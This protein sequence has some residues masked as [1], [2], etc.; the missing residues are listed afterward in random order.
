[1]RDLLQHRCGFPCRV[2]SVVAHLLLEDEFN[3]AL[4]LLLVFAGLQVSYS[5]GDPFLEEAL[6]VP[7][8]HTSSK[9]NEQYFYNSHIEAIA[10][11]P[12]KELATVDSK[13]F[14]ARQCIIR[15]FAC[16]LVE[17]GRLARPLYFFPLAKK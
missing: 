14:A 7:T 17:Q 12:W 9:I 1:M 10:P 8:Q 6:N 3:A 16:L 2:A 11:L 4:A 13:H 5:L 15:Q